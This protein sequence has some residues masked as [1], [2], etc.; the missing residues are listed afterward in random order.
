MVPL[1]EPPL[2]LDLCWVEADESESAAGGLG[3]GDEEGVSVG[4]VLLEVDE[5]PD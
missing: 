4:D 1:L 3:V 2:L 5:F